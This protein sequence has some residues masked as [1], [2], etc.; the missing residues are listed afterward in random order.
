MSLGKVASNVGSTRVAVRPWKPTTF[1]PGMFLVFRS[2]SGYGRPGIAEV[3]DVD[4]VKGELEFRVRLDVLSVAVCEGDEIEEYVQPCGRC[5][6]EECER[7]RG[8]LQ[9]LLDR[10]PMGTHSP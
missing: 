9:L 7:F 3:A 10:D 6:C 2:P 1:R 4:G 5:R 8:A